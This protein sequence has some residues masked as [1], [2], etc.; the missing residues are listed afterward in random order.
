MVIHTQEASG[1]SVLIKQTLCVFFFIF[2][3]VIRDSGCIFRGGKLWNFCS[4]GHRQAVCKNRPWVAPWPK[5]ISVHSIRGKPSRTK[6]SSCFHLVANTWLR[7]VWQITNIPELSPRNLNFMNTRYHVWK[8]QS[9]ITI[10]KQAS[11]T[12][13]PTRPTPSSYLGSL[14]YQPKL[15]TTKVSSFKFTIHLQFLMFPQ[16]WVI[17]WSLR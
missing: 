16:K 10:S 6:N 9:I 11:Q 7:I 5:I 2:C 1:E 3:W 17:W 14:Y 12:S 15:C 13:N 4:G 8:K